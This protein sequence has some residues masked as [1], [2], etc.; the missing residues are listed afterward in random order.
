[1]PSAH[2]AELFLCTLTTPYTLSL[3]HILQTAIFKDG[4]FGD[5]SIGSEYILFVNIDI[6]L[7]Y[8]SFVFRMGKA[9]IGQI[10]RMVKFFL[11]HRRIRRIDNDYFIIYLLCD[12]G[13]RIFIGFFFDVPEIAD[14]FLF[15]SQTLFM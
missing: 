14:L 5:G 10:V 12:T 9:G 11:A 3:I 6:C 4:I 1:M 15:I 13:S 8:T 7:L 2:I